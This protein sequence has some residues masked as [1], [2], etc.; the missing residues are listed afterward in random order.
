MLSDEDPAALLIV[1]GIN[2]LGFSVANRLTQHFSKYG[3]VFNVLILHTTFSGSSGSDEA[4]RE[5]PS[6]LAFVHM[7]SAEAVDK[8]LA[9]GAEQEVEGLGTRRGEIIHVQKCADQHGLELVARSPSPPSTGSP[10]WSLEQ[11]RENA[12]QWKQRAKWLE[13]ENLRV[14]LLWLGVSREAYQAEEEADRVRG[15]AKGIQGER[16][17]LIRDR[18]K[19]RR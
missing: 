6:N 9:A 16:D 10:T 15:V 2:K 12:G 7:D 5:R 18:D 13:A 4:R 1:R 8:V 14:G 3:G 17:A 19:R 11:W